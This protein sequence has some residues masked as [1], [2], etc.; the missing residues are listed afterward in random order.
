MMQMF[1]TVQKEV[2][3]HSFNEMIRAFHS[4]NNHAVFLRCF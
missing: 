1:K 3:Y 2:A 4:S